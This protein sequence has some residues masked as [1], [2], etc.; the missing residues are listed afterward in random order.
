MDAV[1]TSDMLELSGLSV[2]NMQEILGNQ[3]L[4]TKIR[5]KIF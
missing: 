2:D 3:I 4:N 1:I 5:S